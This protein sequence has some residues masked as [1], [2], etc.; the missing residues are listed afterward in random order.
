MAKIRIWKKSYFE[1]FPWALCVFKSCS[2][3]TCFWISVW[4]FY[5]LILIHFTGL[6]PLS[7]FWY[8]NLVSSVLSFPLFYLGYLCMLP[9][10]LTS[11]LLIRPICVHFSDHIPQYLSLDF[12]SHPGSCVSS[13]VVSL[14]LFFLSILTSPLPRESIC[15]A[16]NWVIQY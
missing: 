7:G 3:C 13:F 2:C 15:S 10:Q 6:C 16:V 4:L 12:C 8:S 11:I 14:L 1:T 9:S 5:F